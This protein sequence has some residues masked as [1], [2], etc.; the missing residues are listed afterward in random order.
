MNS[1][2]AVVL[3]LASVFALGNWISRLAPD[4]DSRARR[5]EY[6]CKPATLALLIVAALLLEPE[7]SNMRAWF[8][9]ALVFSLAGD[10]LLMLPSDRFVEG[11]GSFLLG[12]IA[13]VVGFVAFGLDSGRLAVG[14]LVVLLLIVPIG[15]KI[16]PGARRTD[17]R[18]TI[19]VSLYI[20]VISA[21]IVSSA[22]SGRVVAMVGAGLFA[23]SDSL[24]G[25]TR[26]VGPIRRASVTIM[27]TYHLGQALLVL[28]LI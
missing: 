11:L 16:V 2:T 7:S 25:W 10:V 27:V 28:S 22:G 5:V 14:V 18:L 4:A 26:F 19:P 3:A 9:V 12:H 13:Y 21:M 17:A 20:S 24:I 6:V 1:A 8:V 23:F 15:A